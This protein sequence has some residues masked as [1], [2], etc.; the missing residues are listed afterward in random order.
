MP[1]GI[2]PLFAI[3]D[4]TGGTEKSESAN[5]I[6]LSRIPAEARGC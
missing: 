3:L 5:S 2:R 6:P 4:I 1:F